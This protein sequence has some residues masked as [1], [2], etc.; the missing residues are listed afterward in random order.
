LLSGEVIFRYGTGNNYREHRR[1]AHGRDHCCP[2]R[3]CSN[4]LNAIDRLLQ[5]IRKAP[6]FPAIICARYVIF[7]T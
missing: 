7:I 6:K 1:V 2:R 4:T 3:R 5:A